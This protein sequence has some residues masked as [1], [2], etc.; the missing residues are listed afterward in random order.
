VSA[1]SSP[2]LIIR[3]PSDTTAAARDRL[4]GLLADHDLIA[5]Q[6]DDAIMPRVWTA[7]FQSPGARDRAA[8]SIRELLDIAAPHVEVAEIDDD[9][10]ARRT[11]ADLPA[12]RIGRVIVAPPWDPP[13][14]DAPKAV[15]V[16]IEPSRGFG[17]G[18]HQS[19]RLCLV[20]LQNREL[21]GRT[22][23]DVGTGSGVLAI[24][25]AKLGAAFVAAF[26]SDADAVENAR[27]NIERNGVESV[28]DAHVRDLTD[29]SLAPADL[30][31][32]N[33]TG[34]LLARYA[35]ELGALVRPSGS[36]I[37]SGF[38]IDEKAMVLDA[39]S[40]T[41]ELSESAEEEGWWAFALTQLPKLPKLP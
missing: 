39:F 41:F 36:L 40:G 1:D 4:V 6:E 27:E 30:V 35:S 33:L 13:N 34:T 9:D 12:I 5:I 28:V 38:T 8:A 37:V 7:H 15:V 26:D 16:E 21:T 25:A 14:L 20:L 11:Q 3:F 32:A 19:T 23:T 17:T 10:W 29:F 24:A 2:A 18:H 31:T 22:V